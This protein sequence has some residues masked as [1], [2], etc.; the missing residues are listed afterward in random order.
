MPI[1]YFHTAIFLEGSVIREL[2]FHIEV[3]K[4]DIASWGKVTSRLV[5]NTQQIR[6]DLLERL[7]NQLSPISDT[8]QHGPDVNEVERALWE[9]PLLLDIINLELYILGDPG[10]LDW[11]L[12]Q[13]A[14]SISLSNTLRNTHKV[15]SNNLGVGENITLTMVH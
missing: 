15:D 2:I 5:L 13:P 4:L 6:C 3:G 10:R 8:S 1:I 7:L 14:V 9:C 12:S 11:G